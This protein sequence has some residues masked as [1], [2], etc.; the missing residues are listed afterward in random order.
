MFPEYYRGCFKLYRKWTEYYD[1]LNEKGIKRRIPYEETGLHKLS[2][3]D[4]YS[5]DDT[6][7]L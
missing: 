6:L 5:K 2:C 7:Y 3:Y 4:E 1:E